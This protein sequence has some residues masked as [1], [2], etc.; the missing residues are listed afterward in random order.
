MRLLTLVLLLIAGGCALPLDGGCI[1]ETRN[2]SLGGTLELTASA[3][4]TGTALVSLHE[5]RHY[6]TKQTSDEEFLW[7]V[8]A[9]GLDRSTVSAVHVHERE[10]N[11]LLFQIP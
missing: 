6:R 10:T 2:L 3:G 4:G 8:R 11:R 5:A 7:S 1:N 9:S